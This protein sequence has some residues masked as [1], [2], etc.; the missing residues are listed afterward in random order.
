MISTGQRVREHDAFSLARVPGRGSDHA[1]AVV[2][3][4]KQLTRFRQFPLIS[5]K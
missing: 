4:D 2:A 1:D 3:R 5:L